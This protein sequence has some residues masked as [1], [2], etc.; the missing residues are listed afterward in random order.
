MISVQY[1]IIITLLTSAFF[2]N[3]QTTFMQNYQMGF[4]QENLLTFECQFSGKKQ[5][6]FEEI[7]RNIPGV[8]NV[9]RSCGTPLDGGNNNCFTEKDKQYSFQVFVM[10]TNFFDIL[11]IPVKKTGAAYAKDAIWVNEA[12]IKALGI[13][14]NPGDYKLF[15]E[16][17]IYGIV[18]NFHFRNLKSKLGPA[19]F[20]VL[21]PDSYAWSFIIKMSGVNN[22]ETIHKIKKAHSEFSNGTPFT[23]EFFN[24]TVRN[25]YE[26]EEKTGKIVKYFALLTIIISVMGLFAMSL[27]YV[28]QKQKEIGVRKVNGAKTHEIM[29]MLNRDFSAWVVIAFLFACPISY[30]SMNKWLEN[31][32]YQTE[33]SWWVFALSGVLALGIA[34]LTVSWQSWRAARKNPIES[35]RYE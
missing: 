18:K 8:E 20:R 4:E 13:E 24:E 6:V 30:F 25:W 34:L 28:Q 33:L 11:D 14:S 15:D 16:W 29:R 23:I 35:L 31:F 21:Q 22:F 17:P 32:A 9:S 3:K 5:Q 19:Y 12:G 2:I 7:L 26:R 10:D 27:Y 1:L